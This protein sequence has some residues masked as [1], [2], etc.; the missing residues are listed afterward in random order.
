MARF[1]VVIPAYNEEKNIEALVRR[2]QK[3]CPVC[4]V[5]DCSTDQT[6]QILASIPGVHVIRHQK[7][8]HIAG[9]VLDGMRYALESGYDYLIAMDAGLSHS[10]EELVRFIEAPDA[11]LVI[12]TRHRGSE[13]NK[14]YYRK[15]LSNCGTLLM[16]SIL[17][18]AGRD[19]PRWIKDCTS[20][21]RRYSRRAMSVL[22]TT[23]MQCRAF[24][25]LLETLA[26]LLRNGASV[27][28]VPITYNF[29][30]SSLNSKIV[31]EAFRTWWR[32][33]SA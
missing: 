16:N 15:M 19:G 25:F 13:T 22:T 30:G 33:R 32:L 21:Y 10:P 8:T 11:D 1:L 29:T 27:R 24:D 26:V 31:L 18:G 5:D 17:T 7:N 9:A 23:P 12:G 3:F 6:A 2:A 4:V 28:E 14:S 20:G